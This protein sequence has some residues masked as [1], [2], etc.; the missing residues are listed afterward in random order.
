MSKHLSPE[1]LIKFP[2]GASFHPSRLIHKDGTIMWKYALLQLNGKLIPP[3]NVAIESHIVK[4]AQRLEELNCWASQNLEP[5]NCLQPIYWFDPSSPDHSFATGC[6]CVFT[7]TTKDLDEV[8]E[9]IYMH[10]NEFETIKLQSN[11]I[12]FQRC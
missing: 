11:G 9:S 1:S 8:Y 12:S 6:S 4:T 2:S 3:S 10:I 5:W 7:H